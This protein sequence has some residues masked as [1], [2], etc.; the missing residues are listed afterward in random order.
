MQK[1]F[2]TESALILSFF[3]SFPGPFA[4]FI[5]YLLC[6]FYF[7]VILRAE[8]LDYSNSTVQSRVESLISEL[9]GSPFVD[10]TYTDS[11]QEAT[12]FPQ[13]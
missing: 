1:S 6:L 4:N 11:W 12:D 5:F 7:Q 3:G 13:S 10:P 2:E 8:N 9:E